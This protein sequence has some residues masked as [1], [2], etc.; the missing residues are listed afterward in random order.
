MRAIF[1]GRTLSSDEEESLKKKRLLNE[2]LRWVGA[3]CIQNFGNQDTAMKGN[4]TMKAT[5]NMQNGTGRA[6]GAAGFF[7]SRAAYLSGECNA[8]MV[9]RRIVKLRGADRIFEGT[10]AGAFIGV[11]E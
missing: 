7:S 10:P 8:Y 6:K 3:W 9:K 2:G 5:D 11:L 1:D 4:E